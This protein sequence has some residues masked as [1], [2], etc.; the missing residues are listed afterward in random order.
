MERD[1]FFFFAYY[2]I[3]ALGQSLINY[4]LVQYDL[5]FRSFEGEL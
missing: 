5:Y 1:V 2:D 4:G 3:S